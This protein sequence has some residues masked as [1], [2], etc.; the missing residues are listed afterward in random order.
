[1]CGII[2]I[3]SIYKQ[4]DKDWLIEGR[5]AMN[6]RGPDDNG[7]WW[8]EDD[9]IGFGHR[10]LSIIDLTEQGHQ[11]MHSN[12]NNLVI[13]FNG[14]I[15]NY[16]EL[17]TILISKGHH[18][19]TNTDTEVIIEGYKEWGKEILNKMIGMFAFAIYDSYNNKIFIARDRVGEKPLFYSYSEKQL[20]FSSELKGLFKNNNIS[21]NINHN[22][23]DCFLNMGYVPGEISIIDGINKLPPAH[24][25]EF[26]ILNGS[27][28]IE[29]YWSLPLYDDFNHY[30]EDEL[31]FNLENLLENSVKKQ[32]IADVPVGILLS[33]GVDSSLITA[34]AAKN[35]KKIKT[36]TVRFP[37]YK[38]YD[39]SKHAK[40]ISNH[41][42]TDHHELD[43]DDASIDLLSILA[44]QFDEPII[45][46]SMIP[47]YL[48]TKALKNHCS[49]ALGGDGGDELFGGYGHYPRLMKLKQISDKIP[50]A[51]RSQFSNY[52]LKLLNTGTKG[53]NWISAFGSDFDKDLPLIAQYFDKKSR[54]TLI[55]NSVNWIFNAEKVWKSRT[56]YN[57]DIIDLAT[58]TDFNNYLPED[59][60]VKVDRASMLNS[61]EIRA[62]FL[63]HNLI[64]FAFRDLKSNHKANTNER[65]ILLK[66][67]CS[68]ILPSDFD[69]KR[70]QGFSVPLNTWLQNG[71]WYNYFEDIL[72]NSNNDLFNKKQILSLLKQ[73]KNG[74][75]NSER[76]FS[77][78]MLEL[79]R[80]EYNIKF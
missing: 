23:L 27:I 10:R 14:E 65:K 54:S 72:L 69:K 30:T 60:L 24:F 22:S 37:G 3:A 70:K 46:S 49:V 17:R 1:M 2:G 57:N 61:V 21:R 51:L 5:D 6:H 56:N 41:F 62:P 42:N 55:N 32:L 48:V 20:F 18:F 66:K 16:L 34:L 78:T 77:L 71:P 33:G 13:V 36:F 25:L 39:E 63:D 47:T 31:L 4:I 26:N 28:C 76:L 19:R 35:S 40:L 52:L 29:R 7:V 74:F 59:I 73:Q 53:R 58:R 50:I 75:N 12:C 45:D 43:A 68:K 8:S 80:N 64:E 79:W 38:L 11:P 44:K 15:Y 67:L 9:K